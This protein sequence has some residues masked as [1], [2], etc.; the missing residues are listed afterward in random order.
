LNFNVHLKA[1][2]TNRGLDLKW[3]ESGRFFFGYIFIVFSFFI[4]DKI[5]SL[6]GEGTFGKF[7]E[8][9]DRKHDRQVAIKI[10]KNKKKYREAAKLEI[11]VFKQLRKND[12]DGKHNCIKCYGT[13]RHGGHV[14]LIFPKL[15][16]SVFEFMKDNDYQPYTLKQVQ[17]IAY[18]LL[19]SVCFLH[20]IKLTHT[21]LKPENMLFVNSSSRSIWSENARQNIKILD[22]CD[23]Q[24]IDFGSATFE[25]EHH[26]RIV[27][28]RHYRAPEVILEL[29]WSYPCDVWS[30]GCII[31]EL[32][33]GDALFRTHD[34][35]EHLAMMERILGKLPKKMMKATDK[36]KYFRD[37][38]LD[39]DEKD[40]NGQFVKTNC[41]PLRETFNSDDRRATEELYHLVD[42]LLTY[43]PE[44]RLT[45]KEALSHPFFS[46]D[47]SAR[48]K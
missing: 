28:T 3:V 4:S 33:T 31:F 21:D 1:T 11:E 6:L 19:D 35:L 9:H 40:H 25:H 8:C 44:D 38:V 36:Q 47:I 29:G 7:L 39:W 26:S 2:V 34:N 30:C 12:P 42:R 22:H 24:L 18:Q 45:A 15:G 16:K 48:K 32:Y 37:G 23:V 14:C 41:V 5:Y 13:F 43:T 10:I 20:K 17:H 27:S 46:E